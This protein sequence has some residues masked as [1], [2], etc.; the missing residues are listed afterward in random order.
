MAR[1]YSAEEVVAWQHRPH[2][3][4]SLAQAL[5]RHR[6]KGDI[7]TRKLDEA[8]RTELDARRLARR[9]VYRALPKLLYKHE[10]PLG[11]GLPGKLYGKHDRVTPVTDVFDCLR[12]D[13]AM[14]QGADAF[15][16][17]QPVKK[18]RKADGYDELEEAREARRA[19]MRFNYH[20][21]K[22][23]AER[24][25]QW[26]CVNGKC[27]N[28]DQNN[29][30][31][32]RD[33]ALV[34]NK[35]GFVCVGTRTVA[36]H[37]EKLGEAEDDDKTKHADRPQAER[38]GHKFQHPDGSVKTSDE[39]AADRKNA[40]R[41]TGVAPRV[42]GMGALADATKA[43]ERDREREMVANEELSLREQL[44]NCRILEQAQVLYK[45]LS[46]VPVAVQNAVNRAID[47]IWLHAVRHSHSCTREGGCCEW[48]LVD[49]SAGVIASAVFART[50]E[51]LVDGSLGAALGVSRDTLLDLKVRMERS[52]TF[53]TSN[54]QMRTTKSMVRIMQEGEFD[55]H[56]ECGPLSPLSS[57]AA[58][59]AAKPKP[60]R[61]P[62]PIAVPLQRSDSFFS[63]GNGG[64]DDSPS[65]RAAADEA[66]A[67]L[68]LR[69]A[70]E[71]VFL[72]HKSELPVR[73]KDGAMRTIQVPGFGANCQALDA[74]ASA[75]LQGIAFCV[76]NA[77]ARVQTASATPAFTQVPP[78]GTFNVIIAQKLKLDLAHAEEA[79]AQICTV[80][81]K[82]VA[83]EATDEAA[84]GLLF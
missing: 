68:Q 67:N 64:G 3:D 57:T 83:E 60:P 34:C 39:R 62:P 22:V 45:E 2:I 55:P 16:F 63:T 11:V 12:G 14:A 77:V 5:S 38:A 6:A 36:T 7:T 54:T 24:A 72:A 17:F 15:G 46:P 26:R 81:P 56:A 30:T 29:T 41:G 71:T 27:D 43:M 61:L 58:S 49:R 78:L 9:R 33:G 8:R 28:T 69:R 75:S 40:A 19:E 80:V 82:S 59:P 32:N 25:R 35:C 20:N 65:A 44:K 21:P 18:T 10:H 51:A 23:A 76:L 79:I 42:K 70:I 47:V 37:R 31:D 52:Q 66:D 73:V 84:G 74:L 53:N 13:K 1:V 4:M 48:R 50:L